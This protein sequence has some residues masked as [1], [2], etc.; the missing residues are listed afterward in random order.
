MLMQEEPRSPGLA[1]VSFAYNFK[2]CMALKLFFY[3]VD[4]LFG[5]SD[6]K[7]LGIL[8][9]HSCYENEFCKA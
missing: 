1:P 3:N 8:R 5:R 4:K 6:R 2:L 7:G 9:L